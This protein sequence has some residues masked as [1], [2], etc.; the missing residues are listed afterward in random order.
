MF[1]YYDGLFYH[2]PYP[3][4]PKTQNFYPAPSYLSATE[5]HNKRDETK[6]FFLVSFFVGVDGFEPP[7]LC[8]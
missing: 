5:F 7:T 3:L 2:V 1:Y 8:L 4:R 6:N